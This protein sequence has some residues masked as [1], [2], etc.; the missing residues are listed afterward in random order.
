MYKALP[1]WSLH[2]VCTFIALSIHWL[3]HYA[4]VDGNQGV[5]VLLWCS[6][7]WSNHLRGFVSSVSRNLANREFWPSSLGQKALRV[8]T[9]DFSM[10]FLFITFQ[11]LL[12]LSLSLFWTVTIKCT[13]SRRSRTSAQSL[14]RNSPPSAWGLGAP[15]GS[16]ALVSGSHPVW[17]FS[18]PQ[19]ADQEWPLVREVEGWQGHLCFVTV[20]WS[21]WWNP[22]N[23]SPQLLAQAS[24]LDTKPQEMHPHT[25]LPEPACP[26]SQLYLN[27]D[28]HC[29]VLLQDGS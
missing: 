10:S 23:G 9:L 11:I 3:P 21:F 25:V 8:N 13:N 4:W 14:R 19:G 27:R 18:V 7:S 5:C 28:R 2:P 1:Q 12:C 20:S 16:S 24:G 15:S 26:P 29:F 22:W 17:A 6:E